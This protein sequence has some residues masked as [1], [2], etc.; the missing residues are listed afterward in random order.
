[1]N[2]ILF[3][4]FGSIVCI[5]R[6]RENGMKKWKTYKIQSKIIQ[7]QS[8]CL[9]SETMSNNNA[10][11]H[12]MVF[13]RGKQQLSGATI[14]LVD[15][16][17]FKSNR[18]GTKKLYLTIHESAAFVE[19]AMC[20]QNGKM[21]SQQNS[22]TH[23]ETNVRERQQMNQTHYLPVDAWSIERQLIMWIELCNRF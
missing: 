4:C 21:H 5:D 19:L 22:L 18:I 12:W 13:E 7:I 23:T 6:M 10:D 8:L 11:W 15:F 2:F 3:K 14:R 16:H 20:V 9:N 17:L 1:M